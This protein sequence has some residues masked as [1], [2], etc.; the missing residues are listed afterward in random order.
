MPIAFHCRFIVTSFLLGDSENHKPSWGQLLLGGEH[1]QCIHMLHIASPCVNWG[2]FTPF[3]ATSNGRYGIEEGETVTPEYI[4][5]CEQM[6]HYAWV[7]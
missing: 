2:L 5:E 4:Q 6:C 7:N 3:V 1:T